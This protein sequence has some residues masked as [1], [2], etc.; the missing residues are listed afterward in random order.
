MRLMAGSD[1]VHD[2]DDPEDSIMIM[3]MMIYAND[4]SEAESLR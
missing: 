1:V 2:E 4:E 3:I